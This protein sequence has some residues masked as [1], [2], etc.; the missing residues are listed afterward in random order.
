MKPLPAPDVPGTLRVL[1]V[2]WGEYLVKP[3]VRPAMVTAAAIALAS[4]AGLIRHPA[5][6][7]SFAGILV[8]LGLMFFVLSYWIVFDGRERERLR[9]HG[10]RLVQ[11]FRVQHA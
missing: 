7:L 8:A 3:F 6:K 10:A 1:G 2:S 5:S 9:H 4:V 11:R